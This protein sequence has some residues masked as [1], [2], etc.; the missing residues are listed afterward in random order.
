MKITVFLGSS[1]G[2]DPVY[3]ETAAQLGS[4]IGKNGHTL[5]YGG[6][7]SGT[8][9]VLAKACAESN[10]KII[11]IMPQFL[12]DRGRA[13][14]DLENFIVVKDMDERKARLLAE[15]DAYIALPGGPGTL[16]EIS[17]VISAVCLGLQKKPCILV[18]T[19]GYYNA[20]NVFLQNAV[21]QGFMREEDNQKIY[22]AKTLE[23]VQNILKG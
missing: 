13:W 2:N 3:A 18:N 5:V 10:G 14:K 11:G 9:G 12:I 15:G 8:M 4:W 19:N 1:F 6:S 22:F 7:D 23:D 20:L 21:K 16:E 17:E